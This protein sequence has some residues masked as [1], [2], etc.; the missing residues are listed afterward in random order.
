MKDESI[1][2]HR[3]WVA[4]GRPKEGPLACAMRKAK[5]DYKIHLKHKRSEEHACFTN[6]LH[7]ALAAK[8]VVSFWKTWNAK[9]GTKF[10]SQIVDGFSKHGDIAEASRK[11]FETHAQPNNKETNTYL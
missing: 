8:D 1:K 4:A 6:D 2:Q 10:S 9:F 3:A 5:C 7:D 11:I